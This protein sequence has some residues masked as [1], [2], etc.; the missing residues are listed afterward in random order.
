MSYVIFCWWMWFYGGGF[1]SRATIPLLALLALPTALL[2]D[3]SRKHKWSS[4]LM[5]L[6]IYAG[7]T[8]NQFQTRQ[9]YRTL[10]HYSD[11][12]WERYRIV[13]GEKFWHDLTEEDKRRYEEAGL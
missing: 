13:W 9:Y 1:G 4:I 5:V 3:L 10:I 6:L 2:V 12:T 11:M 8:L 7:V